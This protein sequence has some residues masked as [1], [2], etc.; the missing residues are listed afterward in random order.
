NG[1]KINRNPNLPMNPEAQ[2][3]IGGTKV[4]KTAIKLIINNRGKAKNV[5][6]QVGGKKAATI[7]DKGY[8]GI[9]KELKPLHGYSKMLKE[10]F[11]CLKITAISDCYI[12]Q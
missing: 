7:F 11:I 3:R 1:V 9:V 6:Q 8:S 4:V 10:C 2:Q 5:I 12:N